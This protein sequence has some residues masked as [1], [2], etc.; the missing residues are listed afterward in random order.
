MGRRMVLDE[1]G[2]PLFALEAE[3]EAV[4][5][6]AQTIELETGA[7]A[8]PVRRRAPETGAWGFGMYL[9]REIRPVLDD[10]LLAALRLW[11]EHLRHA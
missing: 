7:T 4:F 11:R 5:R 3:R 9:M 1:T 6:L 10:D 8:V 2:I